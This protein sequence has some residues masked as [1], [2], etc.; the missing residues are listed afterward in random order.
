MMIGYQDQN[1]L[2]A[3]QERIAHVFDEF[4][5]VFVS[6][7]S[8]KDSSVLY[9]LVMAEAA[10]RG[11]K[12]NVF[13]LDQVDGGLHRIVLSDLEQSAHEHEGRVDGHPSGAGN[14]NLS[15]FFI[16]LDRFQMQSGEHVAQVIR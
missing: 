5:R 12:V 1:V 13:F 3:A 9:Y 6:V 10:K 2:E 11:R 8:G 4:E 15:G 7:S 14:V 16:L